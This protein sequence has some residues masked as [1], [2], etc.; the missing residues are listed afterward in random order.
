M[1]IISLYHTQ[2]ED[3]SIITQSLMGSIFI[4]KTNPLSKNSINTT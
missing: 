4:T 3:T 2:K 1:L